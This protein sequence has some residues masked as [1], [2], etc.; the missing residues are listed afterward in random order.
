MGCYDF[1][2]F[3][4][5]YQFQNHR[6]D[7]VII[8][9]GEYQTK[10]LKSLLNCLKINKDHEIERPIWKSIEHKEYHELDGRRWETKRIGY[11]KENYTGKI[12]IYH[13]DLENS[14]ND[15][16]FDLWVEEG[17]IYKIDEIK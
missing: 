7:I 12:N 3:K 14:K 5:D 6:G 9:K 16:I 11:E 10:D 17:K 1:F 2:D 4:N 13:Y 8:P 15:K